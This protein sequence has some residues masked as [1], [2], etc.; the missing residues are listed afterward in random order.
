M[1]DD[2]IQS[3]Q[4]FLF[5]NLFQRTLRV[6]LALSGRDHPHAG[7]ALT[8]LLM[9][10]L[11][12]L[13]LGL[14]LCP[15]PELFCRCICLQP[16]LWTH[17]LRG[18]QPYAGG[19][20]SPR[21]TP[22]LDAVACT[23]SHLWPCH[24]CG[25]RTHAVALFPALSFMPQ[26]EAGPGS[27]LTLPGSANGPAAS[28]A[29]CAQTCGTASVRELPALGSPLP[30]GSCCALIRGWYNHGCRNRFKNQ[31]KQYSSLLTSDRTDLFWEALQVVHNHNQS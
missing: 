27:S 11:S 23:Q 22:C 25:V 15:L 6:S 9:A 17:L 26:M 3:K 20:S 2:S 1:R 7:S 31:W 4:L 5:F 30:P 8:P 28:S 29:G 16:C 24:L 10:Q 21:K 12:Q 14:G 13:N 19:S 18:P